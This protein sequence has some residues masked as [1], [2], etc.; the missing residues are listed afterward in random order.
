[1]LITWI[2]V[3]PP[4]SLLLWNY[5]VMNVM[6]TVMMKCGGSSIEI[7]PFL[8]IDFP[9]SIW[10]RESIEQWNS[11]VDLN[12]PIGTVAIFNWRFQYRHSRL[13]I[14]FFFGLIFKYLQSLIF[15]FTRFFF[16]RIP[17]Q[18]LLF[19]EYQR[20][21]QRINVGMLQRISHSFLLN[22]IH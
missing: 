5:L 2:K 20:T 8:A 9:L 10:L 17:G 13:R 21:V 7:L 4:N 15:S 14:R 12:R 22:K 19:E 6:T 16:Y 1:M 3:V 18:I 11:G